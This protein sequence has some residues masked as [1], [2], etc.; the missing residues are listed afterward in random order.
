MNQWRCLIVRPSASDLTVLKLFSAYT[1]RGIAK[2]NAV[3]LIAA[4]LGISKKKLDI[5][6]RVRASETKQGH[7]RK[8]ASSVRSV[9]VM[10]MASTRNSLPDK[11]GETGVA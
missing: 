3:K 8:H 2:D 5:V 4:S 11:P 9:D 1:H 6:Y 10:E 7:A